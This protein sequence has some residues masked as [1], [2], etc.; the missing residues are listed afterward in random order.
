MGLPESERAPDRLIFGGELFASS[1]A[2]NKFTSNRWLIVVV[3]VV[4]VVGV[5]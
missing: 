1:A 3:V 4:V 2:V 5:E